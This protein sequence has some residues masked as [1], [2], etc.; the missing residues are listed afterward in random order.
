[1]EKNAP[2]LVVDLVPKVIPGSSGVDLEKNA[3]VLVELVDL[4]C[5]SWGQPPIPTCQSVCQCV[6]LV[7]PVVCE[8]LS[9][10]LHWDSSCWAAFGGSLHCNIVL[11]LKSARKRPPE[12]AMSLSCYWKASLTCCTPIT[13]E[14]E[15]NITIPFLYRWCMYHNRT[16]ARCSGCRSPHRN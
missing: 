16:S 6:L 9:E 3:P 10:G 15:T 8:R 13:I 12:S 14:T 11:A 4:P 1:M 2:V 5:M 7:L